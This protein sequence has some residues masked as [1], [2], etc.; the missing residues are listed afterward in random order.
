M[1]TQLDRCQEGGRLQMG[2]C[3][4]LHNGPQGW[5]CLIPR[6]CE[7]ILYRV[8]GALQVEFS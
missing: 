2:G 8:K 6:T 7:Y 1:N 5:L 3:S 4:R